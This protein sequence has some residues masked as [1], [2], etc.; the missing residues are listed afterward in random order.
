[1]NNISSD[2]DYTSIPTKTALLNS[3]LH[4]R[5]RQ[6]APNPSRPSPRDHQGNHS[7][8]T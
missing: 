5:C 4:R 6:M 7:D 1:M 8:T 2:I 3:Q